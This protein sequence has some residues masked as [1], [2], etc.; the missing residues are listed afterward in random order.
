MRHWAKTLL[1]GS[2][3]GFFMVLQHSLLFAQSGYTLQIHVEPNTEALP[4]KLK[5]TESYPDS[6]SV[7]TAIS[8]LVSEAQSEGYLLAEIQGVKWQD[9]H[10]SATIQLNKQ[11]HLLK[12]EN[13]NIDPEVLQESGFRERL[14]SDVSFSLAQLK[15]LFSNVLSVY[16]NNGFPFVSIWLDSVQIADENISAKIF[17]DKKEHFTFDTIVIAGD[18]AISKSFLQ[19]Y[20]GMQVGLPYSEANL[21]N[22]EK[23]IMEL[24]F[25]TSVKSPEVTFAGGKA[26]TTLFLAKKNANQFDGFL[27]FMPNSD[28]GKLQLTGDLKLNLQNAF[29]H[30]EAL[31]LNFKG[32]PKQSRELNISASLP[33]I[34]SG[35]LGVIAHLD[36]FKQDTSYQN[37]SLK[38]GLS[39]RLNA[40]G[41][42]EFFVD[43]QNKNSLGQE[44]KNATALPAFADLSTTLFG[45]GVKLENL[46]YSFNPT[47]GFRL[48]ADVSAGRKTVIQNSSSNPNLYKNIDPNPAQYRLQSR[49]DVFIPV[50]KVS[51]INIANQTAILIGKNLFD[52]ELYRL[53]GFNSLRGFDEQSILGSAYSFVNVEYR[54]LLEQNSFLFLFATQAYV[55][56]D[57]ILNKSQSYPLGLGTGIDFETRAGIVSLS[58]A[59]GKQS[60]TSLIMRNGKIHFGI[61]ALF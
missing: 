21:R 16:E 18:A 15:K 29:K 51:T 56:R 34:L 30:A 58:Y 22:A 27:G 5:S 60:D 46:D 24:G 33:A 25:A 23:R 7:T 37:V 12:L 3:L 49:A 10:A 20:L 38:A 59:V 35:S 57:T 13:G 47:N 52:N 31:G 17:S 61:I 40:L 4:Q 39:Y 8:R 2:L 11:Y 50:G 45:F 32:L 26:T 42:I 9:K 43:R 44:Q 55:R 1:S 48:S 6:L 54:Y 14:Y 53:G 36:L 41:S 19:A 28:N